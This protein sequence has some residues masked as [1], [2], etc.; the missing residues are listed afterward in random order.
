MSNFIPNDYIK[1]QPKD[2]PWITPEIKRLIKKQ[3]RFYKN[4]KRNGCKLEDQ[5]A[6]DN[7]RIECFHIIN[8]AK[9]N[10][11]SNLGNQL[12]DP[13]TGP[14]AYWKVLNKL[15]NKSNIPIIPPILY[16]NKFITIFAEKSNLFNK[17]FVNQ[18][19]ILIN[20]SALPPF[21]LFTD[22]QLIVIDYSL[23]DLKNTIHALNP[24]KS[25]GP[26]NIS[27]RMLHIC[28]DP[29]LAPLDLIFRNIILTG[30][31]SC[32]CMFVPL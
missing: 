8:I 14:K 22:K 10:Y 32:F 2:P 15:L 11:L 29:I 9:Q 5:V 13:A 19:K 6:V 23:E 20:D 26:D 21:H 27:V 3:N 30:V 28:G 24:N 16:N 12:N 4:Y 17:Y 31:L 25:H 1:I 18:C 7:F